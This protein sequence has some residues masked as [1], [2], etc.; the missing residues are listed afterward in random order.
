MAT[1]VGFQLESS[2]A[3]KHMTDA[4]YIKGGYIVV[5][6]IAE[7]DALPIYDGTAT[8]VVDG[9]IVK[10]SL[11]YV[12]GT[13]N[14]SYRYDGT[15]WVEDSSLPSVTSSDNG[16]VL[17]V[18]D[19]DWSPLMPATPA[20][21]GELDTTN[22]SALA[23][24][25]S[26]SFSGHIDLHKVAKTGSY[27]DLGNKPTIPTVG[28]LNTNNSSAQ[29][30]PIV[31][32]SFGSTINLHRIS[33]TGA[34]SDLIGKPST[35]VHLYKG[36]LNKDT[37]TVITYTNLAEYTNTAIDINVGDTILGT[38]GYYGR[39]VSWDVSTHSGNV[40]YADEL[41][42]DVD[43]SS[44]IG[45]VPL[46]KGGTGVSDLNSSKNWYNS[47]VLHPHFE[48]VQFNGGFLPIYFGPTDGITS[49]ATALEHPAVKKALST[50][51][52]IVDSFTSDAEILGTAMI[53]S[54]PMI[55]YPTN[56]WCFLFPDAMEFNGVPVNGVYGEFTWDEGDFGLV[57][58]INTLDIMQPYWYAT[59]RP[60]L[61]YTSTPTADTTITYLNQTNGLISATASKIA[62]T[63]E[64]VSKYATD[65]TIATGDKLGIFD[66]SST[67]PTNQLK[68]SSVAFDTTINNKWL[69]QDGT[70][71]APSGLAPGAHSHGNINSV[72]QVASTV[73]SSTTSDYLLFA[74]ASNSDKIERQGFQAI[75]STLIN[76]LGEG[77]SPNVADDYLITQYA[78]GGTSNTTYYRRKLSNVLGNVYWGNT[79]VALS[80]STETTPIFASTTS[81]NVNLRQS[82]SVTTVAATM[83]YDATEEAIKFTF[84]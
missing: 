84:A 38:N 43:A 63:S 65:A 67:S 31:N 41:E 16:K 77:T 11:V 47:Y 32:E 46:S 55:G 69:C 66:A 1:Q 6:T 36:D 49:V 56:T 78:G 27:N 18:V 60:S 9:I 24:N 59:W 37:L 52:V 68:G 72:G 80:S 58:N 57:I 3:S 45:T 28:S 53:M 22:T 48:V 5:E 61:S 13:V 40:L 15:A 76:S 70:W 64:Q 12:A 21:V 20:T 4:E 79:K 25:A 81:T 7:R 82:S 71:S 26:E 29:S 2:L 23:T 83:S 35:T 73:V 75:T 17:T 14:K 19:G 30:V 44:L 50:L 33:K 54:G 74:D 42:L 62:I 39:V 34:F 8:P 10:G 51:A